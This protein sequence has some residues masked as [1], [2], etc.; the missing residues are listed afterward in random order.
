MKVQEIILEDN[1]KGY[2]LLDVDG[3]PVLPVMRYLKYLDTTGKKG[4][5]LIQII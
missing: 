1:K 2:M 4:N 3:F 5:A